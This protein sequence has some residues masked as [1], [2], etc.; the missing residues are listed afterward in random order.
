[1]AGSDHLSPEQFGEQF[2]DMETGLLT[3]HARRATPD[4]DRGDWMTTSGSSAFYHLPEDEQ[5]FSSIE[6]LQ[7]YGITRA[8]INRRRS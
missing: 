5:R 1:M 2:H 4:A 3:E 6:Q 7:H 8:E